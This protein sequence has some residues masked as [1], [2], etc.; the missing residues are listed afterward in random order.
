MSDRVL[1]ARHLWWADLVLAGVIV[2]MGV[3]LWRPSP[4]PAVT[5][6]ELEEKIGAL[7]DLLGSAPADAAAIDERIQSFGAFPPEARATRALAVALASCETAALEPAQR[8]RLAHD[9]YAITRPTDALPRVLPAALTT[10][11]Q[12][13]V[14]ARCPAVAADEVLGS[15]RI[16]ARRDPKPRRDWW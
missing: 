15:A 2:M 5:D 10:I 3:A 7:A 14:N 16:V 12:L 13:L 9:L 11:Q 6:A 1:Q 4:R 8:S